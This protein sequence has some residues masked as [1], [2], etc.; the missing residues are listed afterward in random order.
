[1]ALINQLSKGS[2]YTLVRGL[3]FT[4]SN[5]SWTNYERIVAASRVMNG[6]PASLVSNEMGCHVRSVKNWIRTLNDNNPRLTD[7]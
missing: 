6:E 3:P 2:N 1:M 4:T 5:R 7:I